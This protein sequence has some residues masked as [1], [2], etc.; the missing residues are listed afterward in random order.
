MRLLKDALTAKTVA[1][2]LIGRA[3]QLAK[4]V[5]AHP[6]WRDEDELNKGTID[7][8]CNK[9]E[10]I[11]FNLRN[12]VALSALDQGI[13]EDLMADMRPLSSPFTAYRLVDMEVGYKEWT[14]FLPLNRFG[15][16]P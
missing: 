5:K 9:F 8:T 10:N 15:V 11:N 4:Q 2:D 16:L 1:D 12:D 6:D 3:D 7:Y 13:Y 14:D